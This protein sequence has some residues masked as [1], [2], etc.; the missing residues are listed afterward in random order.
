M[1]NRPII[2]YSLAITQPNPFPLFAF[3]FSLFNLARTK[4]TNTFLVSLI[5]YPISNINIQFPTETAAGSESQPNHFNDPP[6]QRIG[7]GMPGFNRH[8]SLR[9][10]LADLPH[11]ALRLALTSLVETNGFLSGC[12]QAEQTEFGKVPVGPKVVVDS[13][14]PTSFSLTFPID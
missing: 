7:V 9:T 8:P 12:F 2:H 6:T 10:G 1:S 11:P 5:Q 14:T 3:R 13:S 4:P